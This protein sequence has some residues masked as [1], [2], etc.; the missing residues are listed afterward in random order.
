MKKLSE[1]A[2]I[3]AVGFDMQ[4]SVRD[5]FAILVNLQTDTDKI[6]TALKEKKIIE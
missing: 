6:K 5:L 2:M 3:K 4:E 1:T